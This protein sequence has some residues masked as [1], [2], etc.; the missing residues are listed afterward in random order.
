MNAA[1]AGY[2]LAQVLLRAREVIPRHKPDYAL[3][4][5]SPWVVARSLDYTSTPEAYGRTPRPYFALSPEGKI[6]VAPPAFATNYF[7]LHMSPYVEQPTS[8][9]EFTAFLWH[10]GLPLWTF[11]DAEASIFTLRRSAGALPPLAPGSGELIA[12]VYGEMA[13]G[14]RR[15]GTRMI[16]VVLG[17]GGLPP[18]EMP[19]D[20]LQA[21]R[22]I[23]DAVFVDAY[24]ALYGRLEDKTPEEY[25][26]AFE[27]WGCTP[28]RLIDRHPNPAAHAVIAETIVQAIRESKPSEGPGNAPR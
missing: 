2:G 5:Y 18:E 13:E 26:R 28:A 7:D 10:V 19:R 3:I 17:A 9:R 14:C 20:H 24:G 25:E 12:S 8:I 11:S 15:N 1:V 22:E 6:I 16:I 21:L 27:I 4:Q 23:K